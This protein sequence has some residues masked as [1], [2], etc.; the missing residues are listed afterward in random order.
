MAGR[1][2]VFI[3]ILFFG[4]ILL[5]NFIGTRFWGGEDIQTP[6]NN[7]VAA[8]L[9]SQ[10]K[11]LELGTR[12]KETNCKTQGALPDPDCT[13]GAVFPNTTPQEICVSGYTQTV[14][15]VPVSL[16]KKVYAE[17]GIPY[18]QPTGSY[19]AD[20]LIPLELGGNNDISNL[21]PEAAN[22]V[23]GFREKDL[24]ENFLHQEVCAG[25]ADL[26]SAQYQIASDWLKVWGS[27]TPEQVKYLKNQF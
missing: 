18:P 6:R 26:I 7:S 21:F 12:T 8:I 13:P 27:L 23:Q 4:A 14:R 24:V 22:P 19:E 25:R 2:N 1:R 11:T 3:I 15:N 17:Y 5:G 20:H 9:A 16:K 10:S